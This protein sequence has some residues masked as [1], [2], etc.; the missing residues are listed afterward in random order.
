MGF[1]EL[2]GTPFAGV[3]QRKGGIEALQI[4]FYHR[5]DADNAPLFGVKR[6]KR[7]LKRIYGSQRREG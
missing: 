5:P 3:Q 7:S 4:R 1:E 6:F 2:E